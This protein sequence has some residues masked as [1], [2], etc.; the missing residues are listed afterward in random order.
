[1]VSPG[2]DCGTDYDDYMLSF[3]FGRHDEGITQLKSM[4][5]WWSTS[6]WARTVANNW[7]GSGLSAR[8]YQQTP[9]GGIDNYDVKWCIDDYF[10]PYFETFRLRK[11]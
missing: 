11:Y 10:Y 1:M 6:W 7:Y 4:L 8:V 3:Y 5:K 2:Q 9:G